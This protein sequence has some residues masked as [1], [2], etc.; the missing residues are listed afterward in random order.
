M[1][2][3]AQCGNEPFHAYQ[4]VLASFADT[5]FNA[6]RSGTQFRRIRPRGQPVDMYCGDERIEDLCRR[7]CGNGVF[8]KI[9]GTS[10]VHGVANGAGGRSG[11]QTVATAKKTTHEVP[12]G[13]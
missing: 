3:S 5:R 4:I 12:P 1:A 11:L 6:P 10:W 9:P 2:R 7:R 8:D 13:L